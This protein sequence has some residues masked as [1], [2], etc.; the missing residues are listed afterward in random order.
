MSESEFTAAL[1]ALV[2]RFA[3]AQAPTAPPGRVWVRPHVRVYRGHFRSARGKSQRLD[4]GA[5][6]RFVEV[7]RR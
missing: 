7:V 3:A 4:I 1:A 6:V 2:K 5:G